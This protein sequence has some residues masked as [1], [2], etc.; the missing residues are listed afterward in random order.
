VR[1]RI[2][3][4]CPGPGTYVDD[5]PG[6]E[7]CQVTEGFAVAKLCACPLEFFSYLSA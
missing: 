4:A 6:L 5:F 2:L 7:S 1:K 3:S